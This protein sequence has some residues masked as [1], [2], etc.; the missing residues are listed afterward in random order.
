[1]VEGNRG[2]DLRLLAGRPGANAVEAATERAGQALVSALR[3]V[4]QE[5]DTVRLA[6]PGGSALA[7]ARAARAALGRDWSQV[8][9][10]WVDERCVLEA[11]QESNRGAA[12][13]AGL[14]DPGDG[15]RAAPAP[16]RVLPLFE[17]GETPAEAVAR[18]ELRL[19]AELD[20]QLDVLLLG[21]GADGHVASLFPGRPVP[22]EG[23]VAHV[24]DSPKPPA[25]RI[26]LTRP[27]LETARH[28]VLLATGEAKR[29]ALERLRAGDP[30]LPAHGLPG[31]IVVTDLEL[32][33]TWGRQSPESL[34]PDR[35]EKT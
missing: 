12:R 18:V 10:T 13:R 32:D 31:L 2:S 7:A 9:L 34:D 33:R 3:T 5:R 15:P 35:E 25:D 22:A 29:G 6:I 1:M 30:T 27:L 24:A 17:D 8:V 16:A 19:A 23:R 14:L 28:A 26:T 11:A 20:G 21:M 4:L